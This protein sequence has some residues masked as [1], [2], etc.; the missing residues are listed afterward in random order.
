MS[1]SKILN[2]TGGVTLLAIFGGR[3]Y[4]FNRSEADAPRQSTDDAYIQA[5]LTVVSPQVSGR[6]VEVPVA[7]NQ[8]VKPGDLLAVIDDRD[9]RV[10]LE[11]AKAQ[12]MGA[13]AAISGLDLQIA[14]QASAI[15]QARAAV[16]ADEASL[17][18]TQANR[19]AFRI[20][21]AM[22]RGRYR[23]FSRRRPNCASTR[24]ARGRIRP[25]SAPLLSRQIFCTRS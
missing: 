12:V 5:D 18:L 6:I 3:F 2:V 14:R 21:R 7:D 13:H 16:A 23:R 24:P 1:S 22:V 25:R 9:Q 19:A 17:T 15:D 8:A 11:S 20:S 4:A 10:A